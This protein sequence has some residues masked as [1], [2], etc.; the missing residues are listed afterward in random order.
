MFMNM[1]LKDSRLLH[2]S[3]SS[4]KLGCAPSTWQRRPRALITASTRVEMVEKLEQLPL[5]LDFDRAI[6]ARLLFRNRQ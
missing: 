1:S 5:A 3:L 2:S 4:L 6:D